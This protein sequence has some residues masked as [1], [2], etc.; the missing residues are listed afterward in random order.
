MVQRPIYVGEELVAW[1]A[2]S[3]HMMDMGG[4]VAGSFAPAATDCFQEALRVPPVRL[5][6]QG[7]EQSDVWAIFRTNVRLPELIEMDLRSLVAGCHVAAEKVVS[8]V[9]S[10]GIDAFVESMQAIRDL[11]EAEFRRR[12]TLIEDGVYRATSATEWDDEFYTIPCA[13]RSTATR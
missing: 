7:V 8:V 9:E 11:T 13:S 3:A 10:M 1:A 6:R 5:F 12:I 2:M 4:S